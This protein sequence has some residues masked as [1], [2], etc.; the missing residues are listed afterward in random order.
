MNPG[1]KSSERPR[2]IGLVRAHD[3]VTLH[4]LPHPRHLLCAV[5]SVVEHYLD[6]VGVTGSNPVPRTTSPSFPSR[7]N[8]RDSFPVSNQRITGS[9][10]RLCPWLDRIRISAQYL[11]KSRACSCPS[12]GGSTHSIVCGSASWSF[13]SKASWRP[14][15]PSPHLPLLTGRDRCHA[16]IYQTQ[17]QLR[18]LLEED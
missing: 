12:S 14:Y 3:P 13:S 17:R 15:T 4:A 11:I 7:M 10:F 1:S 6:T 9:F 16:A 8:L 5:S 2:K 18:G